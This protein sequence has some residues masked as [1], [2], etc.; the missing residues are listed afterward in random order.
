M[1]DWHVK[2][3][4]KM[5]EIARRSNPYNIPDGLNLPI[6]LAEFAESALPKLSHP[7][8]GNT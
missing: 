3:E 2:A 1:S 8:Y 7:E 6:P 5:L 4:L